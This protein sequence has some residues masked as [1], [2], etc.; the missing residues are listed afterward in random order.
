LRRDLVIAPIFTFESDTTSPANA[1]SLQAKNPII[2][3]RKAPSEN[4]QGRAFYGPAPAISRAIKR[5]AAKI[6]VPPRSLR[7]P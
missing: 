7:S 2:W 1:C 4:G 3:A 6:A 5:F